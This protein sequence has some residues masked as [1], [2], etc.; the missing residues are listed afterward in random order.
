MT[1]QVDIAVDLGAVPPALSA[2]VTLQQFAATPPV[3]PAQIIEDIL[4][5][6]RIDRGETR[7]YGEIRSPILKGISL[8][9]LPPPGEG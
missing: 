1:G 8:S 4:S 9:P 5:W 6:L 2:V 7:G 3:A